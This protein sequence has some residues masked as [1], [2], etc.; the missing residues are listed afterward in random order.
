MGAGHYRFQRSSTRNLYTGARLFQSTRFTL[1][2]L[3]MASIG[4]MGGIDLLRRCP[5]GDKVA[6]NLCISA[7][8]P[9]SWDM[10][11]GTLVHSL[12]RHLSGEK[13]QADAAGNVCG[14]T[15]GREGSGFLIDTERGSLAAILSG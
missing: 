5:N 1:W 4:Q 9:R 13:P 7:K 2:N 11:E 6:P 15:G 8:R 14:R 12:D 3:F 10:A